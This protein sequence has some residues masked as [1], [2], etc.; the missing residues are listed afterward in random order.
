[1]GHP[2]PVH[3]SFIDVC[4]RYVSHLLMFPD[5]M[6]DLESE[7][8]EVERHVDALRHISEMLQ[9]DTIWMTTTAEAVDAA[10]KRRE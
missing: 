9:E 7:F 5:D 6:V 2:V 4:Q 3:F 8:G 1:M 10:C